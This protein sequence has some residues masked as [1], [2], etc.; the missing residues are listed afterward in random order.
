MLPLFGF[1]LCVINACSDLFLLSSKFED[2]NFFDKEAK[3]SSHL[4][5]ENLTV[6]LVEE[7]GFKSSCSERQ[8]S[9]LKESETQRVSV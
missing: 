5:Y 2:L 3:D 7:V 6:C 8:L 1:Q 9:S 4:G